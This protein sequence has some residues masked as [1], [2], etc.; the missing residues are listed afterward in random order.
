MNDMIAASSG[1]GYN[2]YVWHLSSP[3]ENN[4]DISYALGSDA[5][6]HIW[7]SMSDVYIYLCYCCL[8]YIGAAWYL[9]H[10]VPNA[11]GLAQH[12][13][14]FL[15]PTY[16][17][18]IKF[19]SRLSENVE[20]SDWGDSEGDEDVRAEAAAV[21]SGDRMGSAV[22]VQG[23]QKT[24]NLICAKPMNEFIS[25]LS[26]FSSRIEATN[27]SI[28]AHG[29]ERSPTR[30]FPRSSLGQFLKVARVLSVHG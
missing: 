5:D 20:S 9:D 30:V 25:N 27:G 1:G 15:T 12:P 24:V 6:H 18:K 19:G 7:Y 3:S 14:F 4:P 29:E 26:G 17:C 21:R 10:I 28:R 8:L 11:Y 22:V 2:G 23:L 16:W 13:L